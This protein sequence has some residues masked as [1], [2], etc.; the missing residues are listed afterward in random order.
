LVILGWAGTAAAERLVLA[1]NWKF[2]TDPESIGE[3]AGWAEPGFPD[4]S[5]QTTSAGKSWSEIGYFNWNGVSWYRR[6]VEVPARFNGGFLAFDAIRGDASI[7]IDGRLVKTLHAPS[8]SWARGKFAGSPPFR[9]KLPSGS[10]FLL[11]IRV[12]AVDDHNQDPDS[13]GPGLVGQV[14]LS[15]ELL[16]QYKGYW[17]APDEFVSRSDWLEAMRKKREERRAFLHLTPKLYTGAYA[18]EARNFVQG[19]AFVHDTRF[20]SAT[21]SRYLI[22]SFLDKAQREFGGYDSI[23]LWATYPNIGVDDQNQFDMLRSLPG[24][25]PAVHA[26]IARAQQR[27][28]KVLLAYNPWDTA[29]RKP[30][31]ADDAMMADLLQQT[32]AD[33]VYL[34]T[35]R[36]APQ[37]ATRAAI[38]GVRPGLALEPEGG[39][40]D[41]PLT[42][43]NATWGQYYPAAGYFDHERGVPMTKWTEPRFMIHFDGDRWRHDRTTMFQHAFLNGTGVVVWDNIFGSWNPYSEHDKAILRRMIPVEREFADLLSSEAWQPYYPTSHRQID[44]S[45]WPGAQRSLWTLVNWGE[46]PLRQVSIPIPA[47]AGAR[48]FDVWNGRE[49]MSRSDAGR[50]ALVIDEV[51]GRGFA[52]ILQI[53]GSPEPELKAFLARQAEQSGRSLHSYSDRWPAPGPPVYLSPARTERVSASRP[54]EGMALV[55]AVDNYALNITHN[56][57]EGSCY[58][59]L[60]A[61]DW[62]V[63]R[64]H[65]YEN[66]NHGH[67]ISHNLVVPHL[68]AFF[69]DRTLVTKASY[70]RF[71]QAVSYRPR[72][73]GNFLKDWDWSKAEG[74]VPRPGTEDQPVTWVSLDDAR[75]Y[76]KWAGARLPMEEEWQFAAGG[77][78]GRRYPWGFSWKSG[79]SNDKGAATTPVTAFPAGRTPEGLYDMTGNVWEWTESERNDGNRYVMLRGGS[80]YQ[81]NGSS[82]YFDRFVEMGLAQGEWSARPAGYHVKFFEMAPSLDRKATIGFRTVKDTE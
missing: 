43:N 30:E 57:G 10:R 35:G 67:T 66:G 31:K 58:P 53:Q 65:M 3:K 71:L 13:A 51:E 81:V 45:Y 25:L 52:A 50:L 49:L 60:P 2:K 15:T 36:D 38:D 62:D 22:D 54:P 59:D 44:A 9:L 34:D 70:L 5:W 23:I 76:A 64:E 4:S 14:S 8:A 21:E 47:T 7:Y 6:L 18:W 32:G 12:T 27:G 39:Q 37:E 75:A 29:T 20:Y 77:K 19:V 42:T 55:P 11:A 61:E 40:S 28:V 48:Y 68:G 1:S 78:E 41:E 69:M 33:G 72:D 24:G 73:A 56:L 80:F 46:E 74:P 26:M 82:W 79:L 63:L 16:E 17:L